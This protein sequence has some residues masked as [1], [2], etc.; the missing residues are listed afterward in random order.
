[1]WLIP[2]ALALFL[3]VCMARYD[4]LWRARH[5]LAEAA[6][7]MLV[8]GGMFLS[9]T[10]FALALL[11]MLG[12]LQAWSVLL[13]GRL[14]FGRLPEKFLRRSTVLNAALSLVVLVVVVDIRLV[15]S[16]LG[17]GEVSL[18]KLLIALLLVSAV[19]GLVFLVQV[20]WT[21][22][23][24]RLRRLDQMLRPKALPT[25]TLAIPARNET[26]ALQACLQA[27]VAS[28]YPK[29][30]VL[31]LDDCSQDKT[32][33]IIRSFAHQG[34]RFV[35]G[36][37]PAEGWL[38]KNQ[39][40]HTL[41]Q[42]ANGDYIV[43]MDVDTH[44][45]PQSISKLIN[46]AVSHKQEMLTILPTR[47]DGWTPATLLTTLRYYW[48]V[49]LPITAR[50]VPVASQCWLIRRSTLTKLGGFDAV[51]HKITPEGYF[52]RILF[53]HDQYRFLV[54]N[55]ELGISTAK[56]W[57]SQLETSIRYLYPTFKRQSLLVLAVCV[58]LVGLFVSPFATL[59][60]AP[61]H[62]PQLL[63][64]AAVAC[65]L[66]WLGYAL[67]IVRTHIYTWPVTLLLLPFSLLQE[68]ILLI[69]SMILYEF[70]EVNW[71]GRNVCYPVIRQVPTTAKKDI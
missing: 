9:T 5:V 65:G 41:S 23:H 6:V 11:V 3:L 10:D 26:H 7:G 58:A 57:S 55:D 38:G 32:S 24:Y 64:P 1:M 62:D 53:V 30:E 29:L 13:A 71:K 67:V 36:D 68:F 44:L 45:E 35:Q 51:Q 14:L 59:V 46:Y 69:V 22:Q 50:R 27:A 47:R 34:V 54:S 8:A 33:E 48:Q 42:D 49:A 31:V 20:M 19:I 18:E 37:V 56:R 66:L 60:V 70:G 4:R 39:A 43:F 52:A 17:I 28:D 12:L 40:L 63:V 2:T 21:L 16:G 25:V 15:L 61:V